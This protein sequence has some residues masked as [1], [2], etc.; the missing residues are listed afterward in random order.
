M[1]NYP[2]WNKARQIVLIDLERVLKKIDLLA[3]NGDFENKT[4]SQE[5][6]AKIYNEIEIQKRSLKFNDLL[7]E[8]A[9]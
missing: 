5:V 1:M 3:L 9:F 6:L 4:A 7:W 8:K 2:N